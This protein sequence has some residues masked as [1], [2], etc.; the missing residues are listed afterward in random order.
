MPDAVHAKQARMWPIPLPA[1]DA[2]RANAYVVNRQVMELI[3]RWEGKKRDVSSE[4]TG[5]LHLK[6]PGLEFIT[7]K[8]TAA[9][10]AFGKKPP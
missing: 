10:A 9:M 3:R 8:A 2:K 7:K 5:A 6:G 4:E 1:A